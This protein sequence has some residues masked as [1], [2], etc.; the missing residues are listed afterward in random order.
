MKEV[1]T[2]VTYVS[3]FGGKDEVVAVFTDRSMSATGNYW[4][5]EVKNGITLSDVAE[6][7]Y[8]FCN[9]PNAVN[10]IRVTIKL[11]GHSISIDIPN[12]SKK[13]IDYYLKE[14]ASELILG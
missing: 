1:I 2:Q 14:I 5:C 12:K 6:L 10:A 4:N 11:N 7:I 3:T 13:S 8:T 9:S